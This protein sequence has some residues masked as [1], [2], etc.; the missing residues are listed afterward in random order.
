MV[1][2]SKKYE[3]KL[4]EAVDS[5]INGRIG[6]AERLYREVLAGNPQDAIA[7]HY[8]G[9]I[10]YHRGEFVEAVDL[11]R[12]SLSI[13]PNSA[14][15]M[16]NLGLV[17]VAQEKTEEAIALYRKAIALKPDN[18]DNY[19]NLASALLI[20]KKL[21]ESIEA[22]QQAIRLKPSF[23]IAYYNLGIAIQQKGM[24]EEAIKTFERAINL[25]PNFPEAYCNIGL[26]YMD[27]GKREEAISAYRKA[28]ELRPNFPEAFNNLGQP[29]C[30]LRRMEEASDAYRQ[31]VTLRPTYISAVG[32]LATTLRKQGMLEEALRVYEQGLTFCPGDI[33]AEIEIMNLR[34]HVCEWKNFESDTRRLLE[35]AD[36][37]EPFVFLNVPSKPEEQLRCARKWASKLTRGTAFD[38]SRVRTPGRIR[39]GYLSA[40]FRRHAT[41]Y[42]MAELFERHDHAR[43]EIFA[44]S[45]GY[46]DGSAIRQRLV[47]S[48]DH[49]TDLY[50]VSR[51][52][53][54]QRIYDDRIDILIDLKGYTGEA[55]TEILVNRPAPI[56]VN[57]VGYPGTMGADF[58]DYII[59]DSFVAP[60]EHQPFFDEKIIHLPN[61]YQ[62]NDTKRE[63]SDRVIMRHECK[64]PDQGFVFCSFNGS[65]KITPIMFD[66]W[67]RLL[68]AVPGSVLWLLVTTPVIEANIRREAAVRGVASERLVFAEGMDLP[69]HLARHK[70]ADLF[71]DTLPICAHTTASDSLWAGLPILTCVGESFVGRVA[72][73]LLRA[74]DLPELITYS[75]A[76]YEAQALELATNPQKLAEI[77]R[78]LTD[79]LLTSS[80]FN[81][82]QYTRDLEDAYTHM[83]NLRTAV[84]KT[85]PR[86]VD[87]R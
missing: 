57:Y 59:A 46:D 10:L 58:I 4:H 65:Y 23:S 62:P 50:S 17:L 71:L 69:L 38:H 56:Q 85:R 83:Y 14:E 26:A 7:L 16:S 32:N 34:R 77:K 29:L 24:S 22:S 54:A 87:S 31:A 52:E 49:F 42:L 64:L 27:I 74:M 11:I 41:A 55:R 81:I 36:Q 2:E 33:K 40:D 61:A 78:K 3:S 35:L 67:M 82:T 28:I 75:V 72:G 18:A 30:E 84:E 20:Q 39:I 12:Q 6:D 80:L 44:Y 43:F 19:N 5:H 37:V 86:F 73:S 76:E 25:Q 15:A 47:R 1:A 45:Y 48:F 13:Q 21:D 70:L 63:I 79:K 53:S 60:K 9:I 8:L 51:S 66:V 68:K